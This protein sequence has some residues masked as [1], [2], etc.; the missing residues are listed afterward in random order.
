MDYAQ[1]FSSHAFEQYCT[2]TWIN[3]TYSVAYEHVQNGLAEAFETMLC[4][5]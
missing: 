1:K 5:M 4:Y 2:A 3:L